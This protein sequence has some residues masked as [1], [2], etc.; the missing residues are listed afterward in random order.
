MQELV[1]K[2]VFS[3]I[4]KH[5]MLA[6]GDRV[7]VGVSGGA[8]SV[9]LL[10]VLARW[11]RSNPLELA[12]VH[13]NHGIRQE[14][15][16]D[17]RYVQKLCEKLEIPFF[18][19]QA[20]IPTFAREQK[21]SEEEAGRQVRYEAFRRVLEEQSMNRIAVAH[22]AQDRSETMLF[23]LF[24]GTGLR[25]LSGIRPRPSKELIRPILCLNRFEIEEYLKEQGITWRTD[26]TNEQDEYTRN[27]IRHHILPYAEQEIC[28]GVVEH[29]NHTADLLEELEDYVQR[30]L[31]EAKARCVEENLPTGDV[32]IRVEAFLKEDVFIQKQLLHS[33]LKERAPGQKDIS[34]V[35]VEAF[36]ELFTRSGNR[37]IE[38]P[39]DM[40][41]GRLYDRV[42]LWRCL[43]NRSGQEAGDY[44]SL[45]E[46]N[47]TG[48]FVFEIFPYKKDM[49]VPE[50][51]YTKWFDYD[52]IN[53]SMEIRT[54][55]T[56]D[57]L[58]I[59]LGED[60]V[61]HKSLKDYMVTE[62]IPAYRRDRIQL[63]AMGSHVIWLPGY[64]ISEEFKVSGNTKQILQVQLIG[65]Y[66]RMEEKDGEASC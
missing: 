28:A 32:R 15:A 51:Q 49:K 8:D 61:V 35:H 2:K 11:A 22:N 9:C 6:P 34:R 36:G 58:T 53:E 40:R 60:R 57:Y 59:R 10:F 50:N 29:M 62:K 31:Q 21:L 52:K 19:H 56:G 20:D 24:R 63:L 55:K 47:P 5:H 48:E 3:Y 54:R 30:R 65:G 43:G 46:E 45:P 16:E 33:W 39:H 44:W 37:R 23:H 4:R 66:G 18:L 25:G 42:L 14:A 7:V 38:L 64:R 26:A 13:V 12:V 1:E 41:A 17:A 27:R